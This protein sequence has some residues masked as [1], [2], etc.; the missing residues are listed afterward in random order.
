MKQKWE[1]MRGAAKIARNYISEEKGLEAVK[2]CEEVT[3]LYTD[4]MDCAPETAIQLKV[5]KYNLLR[6]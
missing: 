5:V 2:F 1:L 6:R 4:D 3:R